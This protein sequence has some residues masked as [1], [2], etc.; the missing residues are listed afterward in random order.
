MFF[1]FCVF[2]FWTAS[3]GCVFVFSCFVFRASCFMLFSYFW[4]YHD[5]MIFVVSYFRQY[6]VINAIVFSQHK[7]A[8]MVHTSLVQLAVHG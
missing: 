6:E 7:D 4:L 2:V 5:S 8:G 3:V 1:V